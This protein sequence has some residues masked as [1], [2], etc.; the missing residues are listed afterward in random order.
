MFSL[1]IP[2]LKPRPTCI[3][4]INC[5]IINNTQVDCHNKLRLFRNDITWAGQCTLRGAIAYISIVIDFIRK[6]LGK[7]LK[8][9]VLDTKKQHMYKWKVEGGRLKEI[10]IRCEH[11][12]S[13][14]HIHST[15][16]PPP[17]TYH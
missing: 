15:L 12:I 1:Y 13:I 14:F 16:H 17:S 10:V 8:V 6:I 5:L 7:L 9:I 2:W 3:E 4:T 11:A